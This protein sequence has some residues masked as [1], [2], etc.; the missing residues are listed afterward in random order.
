MRRKIPLHHQDVHGP[1][2]ASMRPARYAPENAGAATDADSADHRF[3]EAGALCAGKW[4]LRPVSEGFR[5]PL[6]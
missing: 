2:R 1:R 3:N 4:M 5:L 6:Q